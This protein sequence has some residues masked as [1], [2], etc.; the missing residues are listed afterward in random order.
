LRERKGWSIREL[1]READVRYATLWALEKGERQDVP[2]GI[3]KR[4]ARALGTD[5]NYLAGWYEE[6][7]EGR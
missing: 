6:L 1:S 2:T 7:E 5:L 4:L 3:A